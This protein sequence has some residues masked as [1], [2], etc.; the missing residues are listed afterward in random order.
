MQ[1]TLLTTDFGTQVLR[2][3]SYNLKAQWDK[4]LRENT[5]FLEM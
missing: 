4:N 3:C 1:S 2:R 5:N